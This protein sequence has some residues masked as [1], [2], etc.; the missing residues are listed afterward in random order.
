MTV[1]SREGLDGLGF[2]GLLRR[3][4]PRSMPLPQRRNKIERASTLAALALPNTVE[5][6]LSE[7]AGR[8]CRSTCHDEAK[9][10][11]YR[12]VPPAVQNRR[13]AEQA[14]SQHLL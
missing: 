8:H 12:S 4:Q 13:L 10:T 6:L 11:R 7:S 14:L 2:L 5:T 9:R 1:L 3:P